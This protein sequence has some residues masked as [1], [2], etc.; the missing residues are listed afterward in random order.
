MPLNFSRRFDGSH[1][2]ALI[3]IAIAV[4]AVA[5]VL[6]LFLFRH[7]SEGPPVTFEPQPLPAY[8]ERKEAP[9]L[10]KLVSQGKLPPLKERLPR[11]RGSWAG[12]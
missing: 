6:L 2:L 5:A 7:N 3:P 10:E 8:L 11:T 1:K 9:M 12:E 4:A